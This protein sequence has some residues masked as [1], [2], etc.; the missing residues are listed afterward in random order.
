MRRIADWQT[1]HFAREEK[2]RKQ[3]EETQTKDEDQHKD[4]KVAASFV[5]TKFFAEVKFLVILDLHKLS[6]LQIK[7]D[8]TPEAVQFGP[9]KPAVPEDPVEKNPNS[10]VF[11]TSAVIK[12]NN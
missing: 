2:K 1:Q 9:V 6:A 10:E 12:V 4:K 5:K 7:S 3:K 8:P 11:D